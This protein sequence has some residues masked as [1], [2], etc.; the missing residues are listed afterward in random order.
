MTCPG[1]H[2]SCRRGIGTQ[3]FLFKIPGT[4]ALQV[5]WLAATPLA[6]SALFPPWECQADPVG[7]PFLPYACFLPLPLLIHGQVIPSPSGP[8]FYPFILWAPCS[9]YCLMHGPSHWCW[10]ICTPWLRLQ[11]G[12]WGVVRDGIQDGALDAPLSLGTNATCFSTG[13]SLSMA[14]S[15]F[16]PLQDGEGRSRLPQ[17]EDEFHQKR[18]K[19]HN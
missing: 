19:K 18:V 10:V 3:V 12:S 16:F 6:S 9:S 7:G 2:V 11:A 8:S 17:F 1:S 15:Q 13:L 4:P 14:R 5:S